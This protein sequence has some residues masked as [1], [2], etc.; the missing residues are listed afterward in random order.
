MHAGGGAKKSKHACAM[1]GATSKKDEGEG[2]SN[3]GKAGKLKKCS[4]CGAKRYCSSECQK[5]H[6]KAG[7]KA[8]CNWKSEK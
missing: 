2:S 5:A 3:G 1:C 8:E 4:G 7:H 6:W